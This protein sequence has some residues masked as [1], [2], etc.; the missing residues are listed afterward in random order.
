M[1]LAINIV[2]QQG[3]SALYSGLTASLLRQLTYSTARFGIYE[4]LDNLF[5]KQKLRKSELKLIYI[6]SGV[7]TVR[8][9]CKSWQ[10]SFLSES[11]D[12]WFV[13][14]MWW[15]CWNTRWLDKCPHAKRCQTSSR[16]TAKVVHHFQRPFIFVHHLECYCFSFSYKH[17]IDGVFRVYREEGFRRLFSGASTATGRAILMTIGQLSFYD[18]IKIMLLN[19]GYFQD[20]LVTHLAASMSAVSLHLPPCKYSDMTISVS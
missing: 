7:Q 10:H 19:T 20:N 4:V 16:T 14:S 18:Q 1:R 6:F 15:N 11:N 2:K 5:L 9:W 17:A 13:W 3:I 12:S 8:W